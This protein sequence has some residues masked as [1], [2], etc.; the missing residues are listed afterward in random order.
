MT[1]GPNASLDRIDLFRSLSAEERAALA[2]QCAWRHFH[3]QEQIVDQDSDT[4]DLCIIVEGRVRVVNHS[5]SG[6]EITFDDI[7]AGGWLGELATIDGEP[8]SAGIVAL[9]ETWVA[10]MSPRLFQETVLTHPEV[11]L[12]V[13]RRLARMV[14]TAT[15]RIMDLSTLG[16]N[17]RVHAEILRL[18][19]PGLKDDGTTAEISPIPIHSDI[20]SRVSTTRETVAR[21]LSDLSRDGLVVRKGNALVV[22]DFDKLEEMVEDVRGA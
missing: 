5:V 19:K 22:T 20:A 16:A 2:K 15:G 13:M 14:R 21:V 4:R 12:L 3:A 18:A 9:T 7:G 1:D 17:N 6:R 11:G 8:R 10:F